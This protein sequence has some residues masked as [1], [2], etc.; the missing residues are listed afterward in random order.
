MSILLAQKPFWQRH[1]AYPH[2]NLDTV[3]HSLRLT[4]PLDTTLLLRALYLTINEIDLF[5]ARFSAQGELYWHPFS[6]TIDYQDLSIHL[7]A[8]PLAWRQIEQD[9][10]RPTTLIDAPI[11][12]HQVYRLSHNEHLIYTRTH[13]IVLDGYGMMLF[14]QRLS[15]HYQ[16]LFSG[17]TPT[18]AFKPYQ[19]Y[20]EEEAAYLTS[21]RYWQDKQFWQGYLREAPDLALTS[22]TYDPQLSHAVS[23]SYTLDSQLNHL[24]LKLANA[25]QIGWP[26]ALVALCALYLESAEPDTP[27]LWLPFM[28]RWGSVAANVPG[29]MVNS[30]P[31][32]R[33][34]AQQT[35]LGNYLKQSGQALRS[36]YLHGRYRIEQIEQD[37]GLNA[38]QSYFMSPFINILPF[39]SPHFAD[40]QTELKVLASG[41]AEGINF[42][43][44]GSPQHE[45]CL[46]ITADLASYPQPHWQSHCE[47][48][49]R[50][51]EQLLARFQQVEQDVARLLAEPAALATATSTQAIAS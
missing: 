43:F 36:L 37:Q 14:E 40:C 13:H 18:A 48:L 15:Q 21:H 46:D 11:T 32:L 8:E 39:E 12:S 5:R 3:A 24:L 16:S 19:S 38:E 42:T 49:P 23:L 22:A 7:E 45:L 26:D 50:F 20:L 30:L 35:S 25:S 6:P 27:W 41:S 1:L 10:Q 47:R 31:L 28:N 44:R 17:Q 4:G 51:F 34:S 2:I 33:L 9:L 29:L